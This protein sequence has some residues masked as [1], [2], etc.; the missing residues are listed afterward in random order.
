LDDK[1]R[2]ILDESDEI[3]HVRYQLI[4]SIGARRPLEHHPDRWTTIQQVF[5]LV[6]KH[7]PAVQK[8]SQ[9][10]IE[11]RDDGRQGAFPYV[12]ILQDGAAAELISLIARDI[13]NS[14]LPNISFHRYPKRFRDMAMDFITNKHIPD[15]TVRLIKHQCDESAGDWNTLL[16]IRGFLAHEIL[17]FTL[18]EKRWRVDYGLDSSRT[19]LAVPYRA[20]D[21]P[22]LRSEF[23]HPEVAIALTCLSYY[24]SG[25]SEEQLGLCFERLLMLDNSA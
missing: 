9:F 4:Y 24:Y 16:L 7:A 8:V 10:G 20:K 14:S 3:L 13:C 23:G 6:R 11:I 25:L 21:C 22:T 12:R 15:G 18:K 17:T 1:T 2:D 19:L 5:S